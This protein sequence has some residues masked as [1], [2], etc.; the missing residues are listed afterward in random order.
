MGPRAA[1]WRGER[2]VDGGAAA[3]GVGVGEHEPGA[4]AVGPDEHVE[5]EP[6][7]Q[8]RRVI[9]PDGHHGERA[10]QRPVRELGGTGDRLGVVAGGVEQGGGQP[11]AAALALAG[12][13]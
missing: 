9:A 3:R 13:V 11:A 7:G 1:G 10:R 6:A 4:V 5:V 12:L 2:A 8:R